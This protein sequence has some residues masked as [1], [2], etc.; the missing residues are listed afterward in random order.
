MPK[1]SALVL[2]LFLFSG[3]ATQNIQTLLLAIWH[4][5]TQINSTRIT[6]YKDKLW[7]GFSFSSPRYL[8]VALIRLTVYVIPIRAYAY[9]E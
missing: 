3:L 7:K 5:E 6:A 1:I 9:N 4:D 2:V 8:T